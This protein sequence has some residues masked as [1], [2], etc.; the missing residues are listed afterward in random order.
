MGTSNGPK[1]AFEGPLALLQH[2]S[3]SRLLYSLM[4]IDALL[5]QD[6]VDFAV[7]AASAPAASTAH[8]PQ[9]VN[10][11]K[12]GNWQERFV[13]CGGLHTLLDLLLTRDWDADGANQADVASRG[14]SEAGGR[15]CVDN[16]IGVSLACQSLLADL[17]GRFMD[18]GVHLA[19][20]AGHQARLVSGL[21]RPRGG[22]TYHKQLRSP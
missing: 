4:I 2:A 6:T 19:R 20:W 17:L 16:R 13:R 1:N 11:V 5:T 14:I 22:V 21:G 7:A 10:A 3:A 9:G 18:G 12:G 15:V 8:E